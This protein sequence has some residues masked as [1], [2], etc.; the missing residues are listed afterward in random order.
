MA[1]RG[2]DDRRF[3]LGLMLSQAGMEM[4][5]PIALGVLLDK[6]LGTLPWLT[7]GGA[8]V[9]F[10]GGL[11]HIVWLAHRLNKDEDRARRPGSGK[12][13]V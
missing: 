3:G 8:V 9:G 6:W 7:V 13:N 1:E 11:G 10:V 5:A 12:D 4:V 2:S